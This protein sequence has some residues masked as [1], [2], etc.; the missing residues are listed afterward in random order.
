[1]RYSWLSIPSHGLVEQCPRV[2]HADQRSMVILKQPNNLQAETR[3]ER[4]LE[5]AMRHMQA[6]QLMYLQVRIVQ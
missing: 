2:L 1:M 4:C 5:R 6:G 3:L